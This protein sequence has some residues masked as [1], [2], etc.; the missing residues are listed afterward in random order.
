MSERYTPQQM[1]EM[2]DWLHEWAGT[3]ENRYSAIA[4]LLLRQAIKMFR[5][6][7]AQAD[8]LQT[9]RAAANWVLHVVS[10]VGKAGGEPEEGEE[11]AAYNALKSAL[12]ATQDAPPTQGECECGHHIHR[13][14]ESPSA[15]GQCLE[16]GCACWRYRAQAGGDPPPTTTS[17]AP[18]QK[19]ER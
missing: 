19:G 11:V 3:F 7:A 12:Q 13:H 16:E 10:G 6:A 14:L 8:Q 2:A 9:L 1:R 17:P 15:Q 18:P 5:F 4:P